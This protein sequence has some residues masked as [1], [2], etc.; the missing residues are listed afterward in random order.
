LVQRAKRRDT[1]HQQQLRRQHRS[2]KAVLCGCSPHCNANA[3]QLNQHLNRWAASDVLWSPQ[4][5]TQ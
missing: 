5:N 4:P 2:Q 3:T 1:S